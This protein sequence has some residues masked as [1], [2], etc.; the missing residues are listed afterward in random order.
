MDKD[1]Y[2]ERTESFRKDMQRLDP[3]CVHV[4]RPKLLRRSYYIHYS[5]NSLNNGQRAIGDTFFLVVPTTFCTLRD[6]LSPHS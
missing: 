6:S 1:V 2:S 5:S 3:D 4:R